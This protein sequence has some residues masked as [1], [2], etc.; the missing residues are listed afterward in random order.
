MTSRFTQGHQF[1]ASGLEAF[2]TWWQK[3]CRSKARVAPYRGCPPRSRSLGKQVRGDPH[4]SGTSERGQ[5]GI[6]HWSHS[7]SPRSLGVVKQAFKRREEQ[8]EEWGRCDVFSEG[9]SK[10]LLSLMRM[11]KLWV[12]PAIFRAFSSY[13][14]GEDCKGKGRRVNK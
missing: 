3:L 5:E 2:L 11:S 7:K 6:L 1:E 10:L 9:S 12:S 14:N 8:D 13:L 4:L